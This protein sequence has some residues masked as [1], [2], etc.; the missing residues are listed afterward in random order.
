MLSGG[1]FDSDGDEEW[2][3]AAT[4]LD[5]WVIREG[6]HRGMECRM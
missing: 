1:L 4:E 2:K 3:R 5:S 6:I